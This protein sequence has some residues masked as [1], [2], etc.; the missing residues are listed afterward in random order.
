MDDQKYGTECR[1]AGLDD[2]WMKKYNTR[3]VGPLV[4]TTANKN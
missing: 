3:W 1:A 4:L 2:S